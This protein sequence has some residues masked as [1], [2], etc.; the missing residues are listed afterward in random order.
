MA[1]SVERVERLRQK[2]AEWQLDAVMITQDVSRYYLSG[3]YAHDGGLDIAGQLLI[4]RETMALV[5]DGRYTEQATREAPGLKLVVRQ[6][7]FAPILAE[8]FRQEGWK[9]VGFQAEWVTVAAHEALLAES[10]DTFELKALR[11]V[12]EPLREFK[13]ADELARIQKA[14]D[15]TDATF[16]HLLGWLRPGITE[17]A[18]AAE[19]ERFMV[20]QGAEGIAFPPIIASGPNAALP[21]AVPGERKLAQGEPLTIDMGAR[22]RGYRSDMTRTICLGQP[23]AK[24]REIYP[25]VLQA[26]M[27]CIAGL[28]AGIGGKAADALAREPIEKAGYGAEYLHGTGHGVGLDI[29]ENPRLSKYADDEKEQLGA[30]AVVTI[31]P[32]IYI[33][34]WGGVRIEDMGVITPDGIEIFTHSSKE[35][36]AI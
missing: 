22:Y 9:R 21:H 2:L 27:H 7:A 17:R 19:I 20:E 13:D 18:V 10:H 29:H 14:Q 26:Q 3:F 32:G 24:M 12:V 4:G 28:H 11:N 35:L 5:T 34:G 25:I 6:A 1:T 30:G 15:I 36:L 31:E 8:T 16:T 23:D 33:S